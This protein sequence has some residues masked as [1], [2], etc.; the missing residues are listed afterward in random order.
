M[1]VKKS[2]GKWMTCFDYTDLKK[3]CPK[4]CYP[5]S[6]IEQLVEA[7]SGH[8]LLSLIDGYSRYNLIHIYKPDE[9]H[10]SFII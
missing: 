3:A 9:E 10:T 7:T 2:N 5:L 1:L 6:R 8:K 4:N